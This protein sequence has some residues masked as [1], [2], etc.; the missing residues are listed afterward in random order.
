M[1]TVSCPALVAVSER[2]AWRPGAEGLACAVPRLIL[3]GDPAGSVSQ[4]AS[5]A[6]RT[7]PSVHPEEGKRPSL[8]L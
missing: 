7:Q 8:S 3:P 1:F 4:E 6:P 2:G 5:G